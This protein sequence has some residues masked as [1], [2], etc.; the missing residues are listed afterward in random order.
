M[1]DIENRK[2]AAKALLFYTDKKV[3]DNELRPKAFKVVEEKKF[4]KFANDIE[5]FI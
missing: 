3:K 5:A 4:K 1:K 2:L